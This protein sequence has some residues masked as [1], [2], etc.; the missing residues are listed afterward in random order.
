MTPACV[1]QRKSRRRDS[2]Q[3]QHQAGAIVDIGIDKKDRDPHDT[4]AVATQSGL[5]ESRWSDP[6]RGAFY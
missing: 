4:T 1:A 5:Y 6:S 3:L 2:G